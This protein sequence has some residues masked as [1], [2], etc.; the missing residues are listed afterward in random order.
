M[1]NPYI[2]LF[3]FLGTLAIMLYHFEWLYVGKS[4]FL[5]NHYIWVE[6]FF[7]LSGFFIASKARLAA[8]AGGRARL[9]FRP[10]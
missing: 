9:L 1:R 6:M 3:R 10:N 8:R 2:E 7:V 5:T 4:V